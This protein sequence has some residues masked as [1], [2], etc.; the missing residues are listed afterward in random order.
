M[1]DRDITTNELLEFLQENMVTKEDA[2]SFVTKDDAKSF[3]TKE[4]LRVMEHRILDHMDDK[5]ADLEGSIV[6]RQRKEDNRFRRLLEGLEKFKVLPKDEIDAVRAI[7]VFP[8]I[9]P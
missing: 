8:Q 9:T 4:D 6:A 3:A 2:K 1:T 5:L 7:Q